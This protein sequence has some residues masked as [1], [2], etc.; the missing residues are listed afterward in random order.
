MFLNAIVNALTTAATSGLLALAQFIP[1]LIAGIIVILIGLVVAAIVH[2]IVAEITKA[3]KLEALLKKYGVPEAKGG[4]GWSNIIAEVVRWFVILIFLIPAV[5]VWG[6]PRVSTVI[7]EVLLY[8]PNVLVAAIIAVV[9]MVIANLAHD[10][11]LASVR[12]VSSEVAE[13]AAVITKWAIIAFVILA[14]LTQLG[15]AT[16]LIRILFTG[17]VALIA[18]AGGIAFG[19]GGQSAAKEILEDLRKRLK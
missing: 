1:S 17:I 3:V 15:I 2:R 14:V 10:I 4:L 6:I 7:N 8:L 9:G 19:L 11:V 12:G 16:D 18:L 5:E 13:T